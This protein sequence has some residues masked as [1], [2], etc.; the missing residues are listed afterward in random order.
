MPAAIT[1]APATMFQRILSPNR[2]YPKTMAQSMLIARFA[3]AS[4]SGIL[5]RNCCQQTA[6]TPSRRIPAP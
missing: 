5:L 3:Y 4:E 2:K 6:Y 1:A